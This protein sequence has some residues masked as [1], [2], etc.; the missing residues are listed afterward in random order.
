MPL[1]ITALVAGLN[2][3]ILL[4]LVFRVVGLRRSRQIA[5]GDG[6]DK[7]LVRAMRGH[8]NAAETIP[9]GV[10]LVGL[11]ESSAAPAWIALALGVAFTLG[12]ALHGWYFAHPGVT[13]R[14]RF[15]GMLLTV[16]AIGAAAIGLIGHA[17]VNVLLMGGGS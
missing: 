16:T 3:L 10:I 1:P 2:A 11:V 17:L 9:I 13:W 6:G 7:D 15:Y 12:R 5:F 14:L 4:M 8:A